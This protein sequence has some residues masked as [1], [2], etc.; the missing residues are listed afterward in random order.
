M[1]GFVGLYVVGDGWRLCR[2]SFPLQDLLGLHV[3]SGPCSCTIATSQE[4]TVAY[5]MD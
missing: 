3:C 5:M 4:F 2:G 1:A